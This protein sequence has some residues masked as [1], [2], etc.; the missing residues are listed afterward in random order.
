MR[1]YR[2]TFEGFGIPA[3]SA[4]G[5]RVVVGAPYEPKAL[6]IASLGTDAL[7]RV[8]FR[9]HAPSPLIDKDLLNWQ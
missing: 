5:R 9:R 7:D 6:F 3:W 1:P 8:S 4:D 2:G